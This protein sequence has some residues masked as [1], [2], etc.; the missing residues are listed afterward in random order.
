MNAYWLER[1]YGNDNPTDTELDQLANHLA[2]Q[3]EERADQHR[4]GE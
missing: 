3:F 2:D 1:Y 4:K